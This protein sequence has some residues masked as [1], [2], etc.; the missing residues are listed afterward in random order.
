MLRRQA[1]WHFGKRRMKADAV[2]SSTLNISKEEER[3]P[4]YVASPLKYD[5]TYRRFYRFFQTDRL[6]RH[7]S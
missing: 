7:H 5:L 6:N 1:Q 3:L 4:C 2:L